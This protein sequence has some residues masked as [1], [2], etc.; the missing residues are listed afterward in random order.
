MGEDSPVLGRPSPAAA[1]TAPLRPDGD[2]CSAAFR[3]DGGDT[4]WCAVR[5]ASVAGVRHRLAGEAGQDS[6]AWKLSGAVLALAVTDGL[7]TVPGSE[8]AAAR[9]AA[10]AVTAAVAVDSVPATAGA[11]AHSAGAGP[12]ADSVAAGGAG[13]TQRGSGA[14][15]V[16]DRVAR[17]LA[18]AD[19]AARGGGATT[20][21]LAVLEPD[22]R[23]CVARVGDS[24]AFL[25]RG[26]ESWE[27][28]F[29]PPEDDRDATVTAALPGPYAAEWA[30]VEVGA[31]DVLVLATDGVADPWRDGPTTVA[32]VLVEAVAAHPG[33]LE[34][35]RLAGFSRQGCHDDRTMALLW[36]QAQP[37]SAEAGPA[38]AAG[39]R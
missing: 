27:E 10:A 2:A 28:V 23:G 14:G 12:D 22:G 39:R 13:G 36:L 11:D 16:E 8:G 24:T 21:L 32:P 17:A 1:E 4:D 35:A 15:T 29:V 7:G 26:G 5:A 37:A 6:F 9:A 20:L 33:P 19:A 18:A 34:L 25:V 3:A 30:G 38:G 31:T